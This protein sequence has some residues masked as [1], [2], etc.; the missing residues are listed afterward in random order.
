VAQ[1]RRRRPAAVMAKRR[2][3]LDD[4]AER[5]GATSPRLR[6]PGVLGDL[7]ASGGD[8]AEARRILR[9]SIVLTES[10]DEADDPVGHEVYREAR[11]VLQQLARRMIRR[12]SRRSRTSEG[13]TP[14]SSG[15]SVVCGRLG[16]P[17]EGVE[18]VDDPAEFAGTSPRQGPDHPVEEVTA[19]ERAAAAV[20]VRM[21]E[22]VVVPELALGATDVLPPQAQCR[23]GITRPE[24]VPCAFEANDLG[25]R[26]RGEAV[27]DRP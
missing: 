11:Q 23:G 14:G 8:R 13:R 9:E 25:E 3:P 17:H 19:F 18:F 4:L 24:M 2:A 10:P 7:P 21:A 20:P 1:K 26:P 15:S 12:P 22:L 16:R 6:T 5:P 27:D